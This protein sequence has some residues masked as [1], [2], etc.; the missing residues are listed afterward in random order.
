MR[1]KASQ[2]YFDWKLENLK[3]VRLE[4]W[5]FNDQGIFQLGWRFSPSFGDIGM[6]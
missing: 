3:I 5:K 1:G 4:D 6:D 2:R